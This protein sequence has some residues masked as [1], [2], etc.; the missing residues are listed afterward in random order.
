[1]EVLAYKTTRTSTVDN[2]IFN[3]FPGT[4]YENTR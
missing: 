4:T 3:P 2:G 1:M